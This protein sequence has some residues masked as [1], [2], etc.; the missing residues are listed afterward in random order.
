MFTLV[1]AG[2]YLSWHFLLYSTR[3]FLKNEILYLVNLQVTCTGIYTWQFRL[4]T[5]PAVQF[6]IMSSLALPVFCTFRH[7]MRYIHAIRPSWTESEPF[8]TSKWILRVCTFR[9]VLLLI[10]FNLFVEACRRSCLSPRGNC[11]CM[12][13]RLWE[14]LYYGKCDEKRKSDWVIKYLKAK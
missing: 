10:Y 2:Y 3:L 14:G 13:L 6:P 4:I 9:K 12:N 11:L 7:K 1:I 5:W 8:K